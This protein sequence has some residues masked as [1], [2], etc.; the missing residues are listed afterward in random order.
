MLTSALT[1]QDY[2]LDLAVTSEN[3]P[4]KGLGQVIKGWH[5]QGRQSRSCNQKL[6][7][8]IAKASQ[9][10]TAATTPLL[11][12]NIHCRNCKQENL[13]N[14]DNLFFFVK[15]VVVMGTLTESNSGELQSM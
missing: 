9:V 10:I 14:S 12:S 7:H 6:D 15:G 4:S 11:Q 3:Q 2:D 1:T 8:D 5:Q 13:A